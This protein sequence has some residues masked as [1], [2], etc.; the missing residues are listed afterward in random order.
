MHAVSSVVSILKQVNRDIT[1]SIT[2]LGHFDRHLCNTIVEFEMT[3]LL[4]TTILC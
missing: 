4:D 1:I 2:T 3:L